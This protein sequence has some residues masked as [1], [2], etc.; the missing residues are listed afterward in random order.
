MGSS[1]AVFG[2]YG[3]E[4]TTGLRQVRS[5][6]SDGAPEMPRRHAQ[7]LSG[8]H[9]AGSRRQE[10]EQ[11]RDG[12]ESNILAAGAQVRS[13]LKQPLL[14]KQ[15]LPAADCEGDNNAIADLE[16]VDFGPEFNR[17]AHIFMPRISP[18]P[19]VG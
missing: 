15:A 5:S 6:D 2:V 4:R 11:L 1:I 17:L 7:S 19:M 8:P 13:Q 12:R 10:R 18:L 14:A 3:D 9:R 16:V